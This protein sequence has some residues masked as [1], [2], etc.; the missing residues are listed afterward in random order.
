M[1]R[2]YFNTPTAQAELHGS[3]FAWLD[4][5]ARG[6]AIA[7]WNFE[8]TDLVER[9]THILAMVPE[10]PDGE[11]GSNYLHNDLRA[12]QE[13]ERAN[14]AVY[15]KWRPGQPLTFKTSHEPQNR[16]VRSLRTRLNVDGVELHVAGVK[17]HSRNVELNTA[18]AAGS[19]PIRL[20]AKLA[21][22]GSGHVWVEGPDR[23]WLAGI[24]EQ[25]LAGGMFR[26][27][28]RR[29]DKPDGELLTQGWDQVVELLRARDDEPVV[30]AYSG[31]DDFPRPQTH[32]DGPYRDDV[33]RWDD[34]S[35]A[36]QQAIRE[37]DKRWYA[38]EDGAA[39]WEAAMAWLRERRPWARLAPD[40]LAE[41]T[42][43]MP[44]TVYDL[45]APDRDERVRAAAGLDSEPAEAGR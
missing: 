33:R 15:A 18:L 38:D 42:F 7:A 24:I 2:L 44:V 34:Y 4:Q 14:K 23:A 21:G 16:L 36:E 5:L 27:Q 8:H 31:G 17:L 11:Y 35:E 29:G 13:Q 19:D 45:F 41:N 28:F 22:W 40:A 9:I 30:T 26:R 32:L 43:G 25:G 20:A 1:S 37:W 39:A 12:A 10:V 3:E 6:P